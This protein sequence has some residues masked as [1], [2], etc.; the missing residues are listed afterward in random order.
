MDSGIADLRGVVTDGE[1]GLMK[2]IKV[3]YPQTPQL[4]C[5]RHFRENCQDKLKSLGMKG[6]DHKYFIDAIF[7]T[8]VDGIF[9]EGLLY[10]Q[11][12]EMFDALLLSLE[13]E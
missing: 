3:F 5:S 12:A 11:E 13:E 10:S 1:A 7:G 6:N 4:R 9:H 8:T 2:A